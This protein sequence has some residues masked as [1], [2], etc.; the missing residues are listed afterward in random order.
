MHIFNK[1]ISGYKTIK[2][3]E[4]DQKQF[5]LDLNEITR[6]NPKK[7]TEDQMKPI[8]NIKNL[9]ESRQKIIDLFKD[10]PK[11]TLASWMLCQTNLTVSSSRTVPCCVFC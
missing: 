11:I 5:K 10:S 7:K 2:K 8:K 1:I 6:R 9:Y 3:L 4:E